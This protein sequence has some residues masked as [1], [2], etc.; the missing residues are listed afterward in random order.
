M[1]IKQKLEYPS[2]KIPFFFIKSIIIFIKIIRTGIL[3]LLIENKYFNI[4]KKFGINNEINK[5]IKMNGIK[6]EIILFI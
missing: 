3:S 4:K 2:W 1:Q 6:L 5:P